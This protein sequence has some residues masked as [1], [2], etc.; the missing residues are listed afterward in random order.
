MKR[1]R[2]LPWLGFFI[3]AAY[4]LLPLIATFEFSLRI[5]RGTYSFGA[6]ANVL[7]DPLFRAT[8]GYSTVIAICTIIVGIVLV[9]PAA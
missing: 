8:F 1:S 9:V 6:Y 2:F 5:H 4:F 7:N 3:G